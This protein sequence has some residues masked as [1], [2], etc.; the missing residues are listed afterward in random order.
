MGIA[1]SGAG[2]GGIVY[3]LAANA[4]IESVGLAWTFRILAGCGFVVNSSCALLLRDR[5]KAVQPRQTTF[6]FRL[7]KRPEILLVVG[8]GFMS[9]LGYVVLY[10]SLPSYAISI[11]LSARQGSV[12]GAL[13][14][15][16]LAVGRPVVGYY[17]DALGR[18]NMAMLMTAFCGFICLVIWVFARS[19]GVL[20]FFSLLSGMVCGTFWATIAPVGAEIVGLK[21]LPATLSMTWLLLVAPCTCKHLTIFMKLKH[22]P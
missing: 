11:G 10:Y 4:A 7:L 19:Y 13:L 12:V 16:G 22:L 6:D 9:E 2:I 17:S 5:N 21:E 3:T 1:S 8:W 18:I 14:S 15:L 20:L